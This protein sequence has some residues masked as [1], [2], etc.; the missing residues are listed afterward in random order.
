VECDYVPNAGATRTA[1]DTNVVAP[2]D[3][4]MVC[5]S[6]PSLADIVAVS[7]SGTSIGTENVIMY[8]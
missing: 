6:V 3:C 8:R 2:V 1:P 5:A 7:T 4:A